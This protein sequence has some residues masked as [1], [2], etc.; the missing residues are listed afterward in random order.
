MYGLPVSFDASVFVGKELQEICFT[1][2]TG[3]FMVRERF[4]HHNFGFVHLQSIF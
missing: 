4:V 3:I 1:A 2:N